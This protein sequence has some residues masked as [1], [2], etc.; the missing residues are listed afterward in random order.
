VDDCTLYP[1]QPAT[2]LD[3]RLYPCFTTTAVA[4]SNQDLPL[5]K[6]TLVRTPHAG[7]ASDFAL[8]LSMCHNLGDGHTYYTIC[9]GLGAGAVRTRAP[10]AHTGFFSPPAGT[11][12]N[13]ASSGGC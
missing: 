13:C 7:A 1:G 6:V 3:P 2:Q 5:F 4:H 12:R 9:A 11:D 8:L 10:K